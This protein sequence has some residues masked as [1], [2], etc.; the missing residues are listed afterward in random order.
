MLDTSLGD[1]R[2]IEDGRRQFQQERGGTDIRAVC[3]QIQQWSR[4][5][6]GAVCLAGNR[7]CARRD[8]HRYQRAR[9]RQEFGEKQ[10]ADAVSDEGRGWYK[11]PWLGNCTML[12][13]LPELGTLN[14]PSE[15]NGEIS[16]RLLA[17]TGILDD[18]VSINPT[19]YA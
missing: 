14:R 12:A 1:V 3:L 10:F 13:K 5:R 6:L 19:L 11:R 17:G 2:R 16:K 9:R 15:P 8:H 7:P 4:V 18:L